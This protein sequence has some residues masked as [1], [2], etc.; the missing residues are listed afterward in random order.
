VEDNAMEI[1]WTRHACGALFTN[2]F[3]QPSC[4]V[5]DIKIQLPFWAP[6]QNSYTPFLNYF[7]PILPPQNGAG[8][9]SEYICG[10]FISKFQKLHD[11]FRLFS[12][13]VNHH[14]IHLKCF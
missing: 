5:G 10:L 11:L 8:D 1:Q 13:F 3:F 9:L 12:I 4:K 7:Q 14:Q 6:F 2:V